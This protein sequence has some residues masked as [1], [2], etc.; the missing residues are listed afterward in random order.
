MA[1]LEWNGRKCV[2]SPEGW[3]IG[4]SD[5]DGWW[6]WIANQSGLAGALHESTCLPTEAEAK[7]AC[8]AA[9]LRLG[10]LEVE[11]VFVSAVKRTLDHGDPINDAAIKAIARAL[12]ALE[13]EASHG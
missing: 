6:Y 8:E 3:E 7:R 10:V 2:N 12:A 11:P 9:L 5:F 4:I 1:R 13:V